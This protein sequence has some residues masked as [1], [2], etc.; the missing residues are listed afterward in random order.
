MD[1]FFSSVFIYSPFLQGMSG[2]LRGIVS[3]SLYVDGAGLAN[4]QRLQMQGSENIENFAVF[5][6]PGLVC[7]PAL[8]GTQLP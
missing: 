2:C 3:A 1:P 5:N 8:S 4:S 6:L 7:R